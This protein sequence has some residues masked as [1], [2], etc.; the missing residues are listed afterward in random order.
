[1]LDTFSPIAATPFRPLPR[2][3]F[4]PANP[5]RGRLYDCPGGAA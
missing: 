5:Y 3:T 1:M 4:E 2:G